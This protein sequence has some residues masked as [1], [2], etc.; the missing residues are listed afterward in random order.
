MQYNVSYVHHISFFSFLPKPFSLFLHLLLPHIPGGKL[1][2][3]RPR[4]RDNRCTIA[5]VGGGI[6]GVAR[7]KWGEFTM[8]PQ[9]AIV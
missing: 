8:S 6:R 3:G 5:A 4:I 2:H 1:G 7:V 9:A